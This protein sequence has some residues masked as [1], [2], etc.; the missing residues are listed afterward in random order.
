MIYILKILS[1]HA[2]L[3]KLSI[4]IL[5]IYLLFNKFLEANSFDL[6]RNIEPGTILICLGLTIL[7]LLFKSLRWKAIIEMMGGKIDLLNLVELYL[8]GFYYGSISPGRAGEFIKGSRLSKNGL[9]TKEGLISVLYERFYDITT[10]L[11]FVGVYYIINTVLQEN[12]LDILLLIGTSSISIVL[13]IGLTHL[14]R[15]FKNR[16]PFLKDVVNIKPNISSMH[17]LIPATASILNWACIGLTA[18]VLL[19]AFG[20]SI[21]FSRVMFGVCIA[22]ISVLLPVT[23]GGWGI[24]EAAYVWALN[25][26]AEPSVSIIFSITFALISTYSLALLGLLCEMRIKS[27]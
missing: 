26:F 25:P 11:A 14:F 23:V 3:I 20:V 4:S 1:E 7:S 5:F 9:Q 8:V 16:I 24:R 17:V 12:A 19:D 13:W 21:A 22:M 18:Y 2:F 15:I 6:V 27:K 10:P